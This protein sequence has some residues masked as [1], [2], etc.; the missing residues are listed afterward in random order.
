MT[1]VESDVAGDAIERY[2][3][4]IFKEAPIKFIQRKNNKLED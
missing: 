3:D 2:C 1:L 4:D